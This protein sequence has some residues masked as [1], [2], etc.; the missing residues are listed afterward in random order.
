MVQKDD[1]KSKDLSCSQREKKRS[2]NLKK[3]QLVFN[4]KHKNGT[5]RDL[6]DTVLSI[7]L[8]CAIYYSMQTEIVLKFNITEARKNGL[9]LSIKLL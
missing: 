7:V 9:H 2:Y 1:I 3:K 5:N 4:E 6:M 8:T